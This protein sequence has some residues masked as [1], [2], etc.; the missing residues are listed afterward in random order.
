MN[1]MK[2]DAPSHPAP[3]PKGSFPSV[4]KPSANSAP[5]QNVPAV[6]VATA[7]TKKKAVKR[8]DQS[9]QDCPIFLR[10]T[11]HMIDTCDPQV[12]TWSEDGETFVVKNT[13]VFEKKI[14][15]QF[16]KHSKFS[17]FVR[18]LNFYGFRKI[19]YSD[20]IRIDLKLEA[21]T[22]NF[23]R[24]RHENF[25][26][27]RPE[28]LVEIKRSASQT[29][30]PST[31]PEPKKKDDVST[32]K[33]EVS[34]LKER[35][36]TMSKNIDDLTS[37]VQTMT[38]AEKPQEKDETDVCHVGEKRKKVGTEAQPD[39]VTSSVD[40]I[41]DAEMEFSPGASIPSKEYH[42]QES[43]ISSVSD[44]AFVDELFTAFQD[45]SLD[46]VSEEPPILSSPASLSAPGPE[47]AVTARESNR[48]DPELLEKLSDALTLLP[49]SVQEMLVNRLVAT[50]T[51]PESM[52]NQ[53]S[54]V[55]AFSSAACGATKI[56]SGDS[57]E[58]QEPVFSMSQQP[59][60]ALPL[61]AATLGAVLAQYGSSMK[62]KTCVTKS[63]PVIP[64]HA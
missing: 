15:P 51:S 5:A 48:P 54:A 30:T 62:N 32:L 21:E 42:R 19:K 16:F 49:K 6:E 57:D 64:V 36:S 38:V 31:K 47:D 2:V 63:I 50:I 56:E 39:V 55:S 59:E 60:V 7:V 34:S 10:K 12:A 23:W 52:S 35:I 17:S 3:M 20:T 1:G 11:Y 37:L 27:G 24:F 13:D 46:C 9:N 41:S 45:D 40:D 44:Q 25:Q 58:P 8:A 4:Q 18:Q 61:A 14:I 28:L 22:A 26:R 29:S 53:I 33:S 43:D